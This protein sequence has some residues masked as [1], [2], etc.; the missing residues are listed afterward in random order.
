[1]RNSS[2]SGVVVGSKI[3]ALSLAFEALCESGELDK[4]LLKGVVT[5]QTKLNRGIKIWKMICV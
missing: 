4:E 5:P 3:L 2:S 1:M